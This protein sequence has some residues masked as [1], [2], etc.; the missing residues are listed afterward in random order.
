M[1]SET[2]QAMREGSAILETEALTRRFETLT[3]VS[4]PAAFQNR[5]LVRIHRALKYFE[6][7]SS[8]AY[9]PALPSAKLILPS[10]PAAGM[11]AEK[12]RKMP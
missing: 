10:H 11:S 9:F 2:S 7:L 1:T 4:P 12:K 5:E 3:A 8:F 6:L